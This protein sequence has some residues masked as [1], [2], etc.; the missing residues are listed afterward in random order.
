MPL[1][2]IQRTAPRTPEGAER[3]RLVEQ[4]ANTTVSAVANASVANTP[5]DNFTTLAARVEKELEAL[6]TRE[7]A[8]KAE[9]ATIE[10]TNSTPTHAPEFKTSDIFK[11]R[12][13]PKPP[14]QF[15]H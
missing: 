12:S 5:T 3:P 9:I 10:T 15:S 14:L 2:R 13:A 1:Q 4:V 11:P 6:E 8:L 7:T